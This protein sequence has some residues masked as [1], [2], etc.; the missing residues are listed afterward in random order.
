MSFLLSP[1]VRLPGGNVGRLNPFNLETGECEI[2]RT[3]NENNLQEIGKLAYESIQSM[4]NALNVD[5]ERLEE[6]RDEFDCLDL[7]DQLEWIA[8]NPGDA[9][10]LEKLKLDAGDCSDEDEARQR[11]DEDPLSLQVRSDWHGLGE[12]LEPAEFEILLTTGGPA[13]RIV[14]EIQNG[15]PCSPRLEVQDWGTPWTEYRDT[16]PDILNA[17]CCCFCFGE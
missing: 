4:V 14:G 12:E 10:E 17:Y 9:A 5:Y 11:I 16:D 13:C 3:E 8:E 1:L 6:L 15:E 2:M 7:E